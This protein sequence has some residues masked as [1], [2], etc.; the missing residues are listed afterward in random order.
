MICTTAVASAEVLTTAGLST[1]Q[2]GQLTYKRFI[3]DE[4]ISQEEFEK[5][6]KI[7]AYKNGSA[8]TGGLIGAKI[9]S[10]VPGVGT[11]IGG[12]IGSVAASFT[13]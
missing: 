4:A 9:G 5:K 7:L 12:V 8:L 6:A 1:G 11:V 13:S 10:I 3:S 2:L